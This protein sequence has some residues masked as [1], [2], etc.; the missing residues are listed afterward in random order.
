MAEAAPV[1]AADI[2]APYAYRILGPYIVGIL[3]FPIQH[4]FYI[5]RD[6]E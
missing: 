1:L 4:N 2:S 6:T 3:P 5:L